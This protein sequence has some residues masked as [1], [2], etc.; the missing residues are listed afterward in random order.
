MS[1]KVIPL[2]K[3]DR[4]ALLR[5][6]TERVVSKVCR[7]FFMTLIGLIFV[8]PYFYMVMKSLMTAEEA[9]SFTII[10]FPSVPQFSNYAQVFTD[11]E[12]VTATLNSV[13]IIVFN[14]FAITFS[15]SLSAFAFSKLKWTGRSLVWA[16]MLG[17]L[18]IP[19]TITQIALFV[20]Y[21]KLNWLNTFYPL[22]V[23]NLFGGGAFNIFLL[24][25]FMRG[26][27]RDLEE[28]AKVDGFST[29]RIYWNIVIPLCKPV[30]IYVMVTVFM[31][32]WGDYY[33]PLVYLP[34][35]SAPKTLPY[36]LYMNTIGSDS[37][38]VDMA[39]IRMAAGTLMTIVPLLLFAFFQKQLI[40]G[41]ALTGLKG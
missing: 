40:E 11:P 25:Q 31:S 22:T 41:V 28:A 10:I 5:R 13:G 24:C 32:G 18:L 9:S 6:R 7:Y 4:D 30:L 34:S 39:N 29:F 27:P 15:A 2:T 14:I 37:M 23:P 1:T 36:L 17:T 33:G 21:T 16:I 12:Y 19:G 8:F 3:E 20:L 38:G 26:I 35:S